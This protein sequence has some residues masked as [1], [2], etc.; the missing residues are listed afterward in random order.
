MAVLLKLALFSVELARIEGQECL[1]Q[2]DHV[3]WR[4]DLCAGEI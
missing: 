1:Q 2:L 4:P 3:A